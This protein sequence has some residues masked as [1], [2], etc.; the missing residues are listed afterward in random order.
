MGPATFV[1]MGLVGVL[2]VIGVLVISSGGRGRPRGK[3]VCP[4]TGCGRKNDADAEFC[5]R[6]GVKLR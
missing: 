4:E 3:S 1:V 6:C 2:V 5:A